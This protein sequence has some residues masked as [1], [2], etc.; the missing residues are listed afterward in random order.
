MQN[1]PSLSE[2]KS[3]FLQ[4]YELQLNQNTPLNDK[5]YN[6]ITATVLAFIAML[7]NREVISATKENL[8]ISASRTG[9][10][11]IGNEYDLPIKTEISTVLNVDLPATTGTIIPS[12]TNFTGDDNGVIYYNA[13]PVTAVADNAALSLISRTPGIIGNLIAGQTLSMSRNISG[14]ELTGTIT[15]V[16]TVGANAEE[17]EVYRKRVLDIIRA[18]G[19]GGNSADY[20]NWSQEQEG[21]TRTYPYS[22]RP[23]D[24]PLAP[25]QPPERTVYIEADTS[26]DIDGIAPPAL[27]ADTREMIKTDPIS[28]VHRE[29][30]TLTDYLLFVVS[31]RRTEFYTTFV[32]AIFIPGT[33]A[34]VKADVESALSQYYL[35]LEPFVQSLDV[36]SERNDF[37]TSVSISEAVNGI[38]R[39]NNATVNDIFFNDSPVGSTS[40]YQLGQGEKAKNAG[41]TWT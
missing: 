41:V 5:A 37:I 18:P 20:R 7:L 9:L 11:R 35:S 13:V 28:G 17:T 16:D 2:L 38:L 4:E 19:G 30:L 25:G 23:F 31:I 32:N 26:I 21:V 39:A 8:A 10:I 36:D 22:G 15:G 14:A 33:E 3:T 12:G 6:R 34:Q 29:P 40:S 24:D 27:L 1:F